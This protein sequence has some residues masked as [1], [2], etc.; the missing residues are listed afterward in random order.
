MKKL[1]SSY[2]HFSLVL[3]I[4]ISCT[5]RNS[6]KVFSDSPYYKEL[7]GMEIQLTKSSCPIDIQIAKNFIIIKDQCDDFFYHVY[8]KN[9]FNFIGKFG[10]HGRG[11]FEYLSPSM[12]NQFVSL[13]SIVFVYIYD[14]QLKRITK[15][16]IN[17]AMTIHAYYPEA[18]KIN[19]NDLKKIFPMHSAIIISDSLIIGNAL[20][21]ESEGRFLCFNMS[22]KSL[23]YQP[24]YPR[25]KIE[26]NKFLIQELYASKLALKPSG[27]FIAVSSRFFKRIDIL[28]KNGINQTEIIL[29][30]NDE[31]PDFSK[32]DRIPPLKSHYH[33]D[34]ITVNNN[35]IY[36]M[37]LDINNNADISD[38]SKR[39]MNMDSIILY[40]TDWQGKDIKRIK[41]VPKVLQIA[42]DEKDSKIYGVN[43]EYKESS[44]F[45]F[46][47]N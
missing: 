43:S 5:T 19:A 38:I 44:L 20:N 39:Y 10:K 32:R 21:E 41:L 23:S 42:V 8:D 45:V 6:R 26:P 12:M 29:E 24:Y 40:R 7:N 46:D 37:D 25:V 34:N 47:L 11:P 3:L 18:L 14:Y 31:D 35:Y 2:L 1:T 36:A 30:N 4:V 28:D 17:E 33:F 27:D 16:N 15:V 13:D 22:N 9:N